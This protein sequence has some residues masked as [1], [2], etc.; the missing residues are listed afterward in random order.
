MGY[1]NQTQ[2]G[3]EVFDV[4]LCL[5][6]IFNMIRI[7]FPSVVRKGNFAEELKCVQ[8]KLD[9]TGNCITA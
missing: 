6:L 8:R 2:K 3:G 7:M 4:M 9:I 1:L 5:R